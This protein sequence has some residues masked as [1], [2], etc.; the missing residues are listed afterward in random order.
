VARGNSYNLDGYAFYI[1][2]KRGQ[3][4]QCDT[5]TKRYTV[6]DNFAK[7]AGTYYAT[8]E[9]F[10]AGAGMETAIECGLVPT[11]VPTAVP[12]PTAAPTATATRSPTPTATRTPVPTVVLPRCQVRVRIWV[13]GRWV[14]QWKE[15]VDRT[16]CA[17]Q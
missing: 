15:K 11:P 5:F 4:Y 10:R 8:L 7:W 9:A 16:F 3:D 17:S 12:T 2:D 13:S 1:G 14:E 6:T